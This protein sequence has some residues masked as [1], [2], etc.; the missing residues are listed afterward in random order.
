MSQYRNARRR[1]ER[2][3]TKLEEESRVIH[4][5]DDDEFLQIS[6][7][8]NHQIAELQNEL[9][10]VESRHLS[11]RAKRFGIDLQEAVGPWYSDHRGRLWLE[12]KYRV[13]ASQAISDARFA[14]WRKWLE[15]LVPI[16]SLII[17][18]LAL[19]QR[20]APATH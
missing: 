16:L 3:I 1:L 20:C 2:E 6:S 9:D 19:T 5:S 17:A 18:I 4:A 11:Q 12:D 10:A 7:E 8:Y 15:L 14:W 13:K